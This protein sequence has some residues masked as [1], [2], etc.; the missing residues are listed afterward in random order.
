ML[1]DEQQIRILQL[2]HLPGW[3]SRRIADLVGASKSS[4]SVVVQRGYVIRHATA[5]KKLVGNRKPVVVD[6]RV[7]VS[8]R[9]YAS[10]DQGRGE[11]MARSREKA[12]S[13]DLDAE[14][15]ARIA[16][17]EA[18]GFVFGTKLEIDRKPRRPHLA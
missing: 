7:V 1:T 8:A 3:H 5:A 4:V 9:I 2:A 6:N 17:L 12:P 15:A 13:A 14:T 11:R 10:T 16:E 18:G